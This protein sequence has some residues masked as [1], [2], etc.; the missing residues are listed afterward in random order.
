MRQKHSGI[1]SRAGAPMS[2]NGRSPTERTSDDSEHDPQTVSI[3]ELLR[4]AHKN[5]HF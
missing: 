1:L 5:S 3:E 2:Q 4:S